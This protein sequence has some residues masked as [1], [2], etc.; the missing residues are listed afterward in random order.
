MLLELSKSGV[1]ISLRRLFAE[2]RLM[3]EMAMLQ[4]LSA[5]EG[6]MRTRPRV[7]C[8]KNVLDSTW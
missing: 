3:S 8:V 5:F 1:I 2:T 7:Q 4:Q 6:A